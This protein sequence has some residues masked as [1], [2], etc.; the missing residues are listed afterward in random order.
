MR[1][2]ATHAIVHKYVLAQLPVIERRSGLHF[3]FGEAGRF[4]RCIGVI[5][6]AIHTA[7]SRPEARTALLMG[8]RLGS[9]SVSARSR[10]RRAPAKPR[11]SQIKASPEKMYRAGFSDKPC[12]KLFEHSV[13]PREDSP[14]SRHGLRIVRCVNV[15]FLEGNR[16]R[17]LLGQRIDRYVNT[18]LSELGHELVVKRRYRLRFELDL[19]VLSTAAFDQQSVGDKVEA[20]LEEGVLVGNRRG[21]QPVRSNVQRR[22]PPMIDVRALLQP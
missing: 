16:I 17:K 9:D 3:A 18:Q 10:R 7:A 11:R 21:G 1:I 5:G 22:S 2:C 13:A 6:G 14:E 15:I 12:P 8:I 19:A 4:W 20:Y